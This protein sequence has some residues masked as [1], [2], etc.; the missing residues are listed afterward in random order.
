LEQ[1]M[2]TAIPP[3]PGPALDISRTLDELTYRSYRANRLYEPGIAAER[4]G[5][6]YG[7]AAVAAMEARFQAEWKN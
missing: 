2:T 6:V 5:R 1:T 3:L 7:P 4:W